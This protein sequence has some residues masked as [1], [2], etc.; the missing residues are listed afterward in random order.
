MLFAV[1]A[2]MKHDYIDKLSDFGLA[3]DGPEGDQT[4]I[5]CTRVM[6]VQCV[7]HW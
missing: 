3:K 7:L 1:L 4:H 6:G 5:R 2:L